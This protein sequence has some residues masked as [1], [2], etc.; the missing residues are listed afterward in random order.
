MTRAEFHYLFETCLME[1]VVTHPEEYGYGA[2]SV[3]NVAVMVLAA[4]DK[5]NVNV[6]SRAFR[7]LAKRLAIKATQHDIYRAWESCAE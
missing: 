3:P 6:N 2:G 4:L 5:R 7:L 1:A